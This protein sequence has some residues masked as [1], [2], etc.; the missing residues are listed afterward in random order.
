MR[1]QQSKENLRENLHPYQDEGKWR[2]AI[3]DARLK[4]GEH[5]RKISSLQRAIETMK[6]QIKAQEP[7][8]TRPPQSM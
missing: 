3:Q 6:G 4:I 1:Q 5:Q 8:P 7:W 2:K